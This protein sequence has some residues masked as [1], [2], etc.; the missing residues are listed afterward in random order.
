MKIKLVYTTFDNEQDAVDLA[1]GLVS[2]GLAACVNIIPEVSSV[3]SWN[4]EIEVSKEIFV[5]I[6]TNEARI[7]QVYK[8]IQDNHPYDIPAI[9]E[10]DAA[11]LNKA[12]YEWMLSV[13]K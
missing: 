2:S 8:L 1:K 10:I 13:M 5:L 7:D 4:D 11:C 3:Y 9:V 6:K 12:F